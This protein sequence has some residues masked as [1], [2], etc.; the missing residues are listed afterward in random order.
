[1]ISAPSTAAS[2][3]VISIDFSL[4]SFLL[5]NHRFPIPK[6]LQHRT[7]SPVR[8]RGRADPRIGHA[9][10]ASTPW[11]TWRAPAAALV[12]GGRA[13]NRDTQLAGGSSRRQTPQAEPV[14]TIEPSRRW[15][16][17]KGSDVQQN[18]GPNHV[19][20]VGH[21]HSDIQ[22]TQDTWTKCY[23]WISRKG[24]KGRLGSPKEWTSQ[25]VAVESWT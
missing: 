17:I 25:R 16:Q 5:S 14:G 11:C 2:V 23:W 18:L 8:R 1:M 7:R 10:C 12:V 13:C 4:T 9:L 3:C 21:L 19:A 15:F 6:L 20:R 24:M 22:K